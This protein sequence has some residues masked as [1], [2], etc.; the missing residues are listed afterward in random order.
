MLSKIASAAAWSLKPLFDLMTFL[1]TIRKSSKFKQIP[2]PVL[3]EVLIVDGMDPSATRPLRT[4]TNLVIQG[5]Y[6][7]CE[8]IS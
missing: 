4:A 6:T 1:L 2:R 5:L 7:S 8:E 3:I